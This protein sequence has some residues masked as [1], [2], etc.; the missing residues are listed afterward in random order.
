M[1]RLYVYAQQLLLDQP[2]KYL[3]HA[4]KY[5]LEYR[6]YVA[7]SHTKCSFLSLSKTIYYKKA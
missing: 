6:E 2:W 7:S 3:L 5:Y 1:L 4:K